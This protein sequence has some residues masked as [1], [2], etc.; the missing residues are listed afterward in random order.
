MLEQDRMVEDD[1]RW[2]VRIDLGLDESGLLARSL[3]S[4]VE[5]LLRLLRQ[6]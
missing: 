6:L 5:V 1:L 4:L 3:D 2:P